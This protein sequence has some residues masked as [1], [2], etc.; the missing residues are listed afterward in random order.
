MGEN[1]FECITLDPLRTV[2][3]RFPIFLF[4]PYLSLS[5][6]A[7]GFPERE[8]LRERG[9]RKM[10]QGPASVAAAA[11]GL[12]RAMRWR[13]D[14]H[15]SWRRP[16]AHRLTRALAAGASNDCRVVSTHS[17]CGRFDARR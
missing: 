8:R 11:V 7:R 6:G 9:K 12:G 1:R 3:R 5:S 14:P 16:E 13:K 4:P 10:R 15:D 2:S 17:N